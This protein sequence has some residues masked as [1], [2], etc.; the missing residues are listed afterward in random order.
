LGLVVVGGMFFSTFLT[1]IIVPVVYTIVARFI[2]VKTK[3]EQTSKTN[4]VNLDLEATQ[5]AAK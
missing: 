3:S 1:L 4:D 5:L 2:K